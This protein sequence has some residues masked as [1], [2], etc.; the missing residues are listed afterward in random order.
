M[1]LGAIA[2]ALCGDALANAFSGLPEVRLITLLL[3]EKPVRG[4]FRRAQPEAGAEEA[5]PRQGMHAGCSRQTPATPTD[6][7]RRHHRFLHRVGRRVRA[8]EGRAFKPMVGKPE[9][10]DGVWVHVRVPSRRGPFP[11][12]GVCPRLPRTSASGSRRG[13]CWVTTRTDELE[14]RLTACSR[15]RKAR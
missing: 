3:S 11:A 15:R 10:D 5:R 12:S 7:R 8:R 9:V 1:I 14:C 4:A 6:L 13:T 2:N